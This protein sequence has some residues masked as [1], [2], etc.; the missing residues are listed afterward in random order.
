MR[1]P[2][3]AICWSTE[4]LRLFVT[5]AIRRPK[6]AAVVALLLLA[7]LA[8]TMTYTAYLVIGVLA[9]YLGTGRFLAGLLL[10]AVLAR[11]PWIR[12]G[13]LRIVGLLPKSLRRPLIVGLLALCCLH[14]LSRADYVAAAFT[15]FSTA[16]VLTMPWLRRTVFD[17]VSSSVF[18]FAGRQARKRSDDMVIEGEFREKKD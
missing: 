9:D 14:F 13:K 4:I 16:F 5:A 2:V 3:D 12:E 15:G 17:R 10:G 18:S 7:V 6:L 1:Q 11:F 8:G